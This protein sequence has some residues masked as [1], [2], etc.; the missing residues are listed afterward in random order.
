MKE[1]SSRRLNGIFIVLLVTVLMPA[2]AMPDFSRLLHLANERYGERGSSAISAWETMMQ[3]ADA[4]SEDQKLSLVNEFVNRH[5]TF[6]D[7]IN[8]WGQKDY[9]A[10]P[11]ETLGHGSGDCEDFSIAKYISLSL[12]GVP[13]EKLRLTYVRAEMGRRGSGITQAHMVLAYYPIPNGEPIILDNLVGT[14]RPASRRRDLTPIY[15]FNS[16]GLWVAGQ[17]APVV[18]DP[19]SRLSRWRD[20][21]RRMQ[22]EGLI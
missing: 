17:P 4:L 18:S 21:L 19:T 10:T 3:S 8:V 15:G 1:E 13:M 14:L 2:L 16:Q 5:V 12:L 9:W 20:V 11:L 22:E 6:G 7:D